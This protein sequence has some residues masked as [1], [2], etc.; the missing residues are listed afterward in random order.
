MLC[1]TLLLSTLAGIAERPFSDL[2][3]DAALA[4]AQ[5]YQK[6]VMIDFFT[7][8]C[9]PCKQLDRITWK[10]PKVI[11]WL[12]KS[13]IA[14]KIDAEEEVALAKRFEVRGYPTI[15]FVKPDGTVID[16][17]VGFLDAAAFLDSA[18]KSLAGKTALVQAK[19]ALAGRENDPMARKRYAS[20]LARAT[21]YDEALAEYLWCFDQGA[22]AS[23]S[24][25]GVRLSFLL[26]D[27]VRLGDLHPPAL[28]ALRDRRDAAEA[29]IVAGAGSDDDAQVACAINRDLEEEERTVALYDHLRKKGPI[30]GKLR[31]SLGRAML[32]PLVAQRRYA[33]VFE[34][35]D[36]PQSYIDSHIHAFES[37]PKPS[38]QSDPMYLKSLADAEPF[39]RDS[40]AADAA[41]M[42]EALVGAKRTDDASKA[43][44][45]LLAFANTGATYA[46]L[47]DRAAR[48]G[49]VELAK[50]LVE[51]GLA[52]L[53]QEEHAAVRAARERI[54]SGK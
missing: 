3:F 4:S 7:T 27:I 10:D 50:K 37:R 29:R 40:T 42:F 5:K 41:V 23:P 52:S 2:S 20:A 24:F 34:L 49:D 44:D 47:I 51:R 38:P 17:L 19:E 31:F 53:P 13:C 46:A 35:Y 48:A 8:W 33:E 1:A 15:L 39:L 43:A 45:R 26:G 25:T 54:P 32:E 30:T 6:V 21:K 14:L 22:Q 12:E 9:A 36:S 28:Q 11:E 18:T 16:R